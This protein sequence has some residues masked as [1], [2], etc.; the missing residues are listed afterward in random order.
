MAIQFPTDFGPISSQEMLRKVAEANTQPKTDNFMDSIGKSFAKMNNPA[1][2]VR[3]LDHRVAVGQAAGHQ[4][5]GGLGRQ[6]GHE[7]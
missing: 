7:L 1:A 5:G 2:A 4:R 6:S 3:H